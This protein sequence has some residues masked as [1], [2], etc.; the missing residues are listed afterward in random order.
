MHGG[1]R[2]LEIARTRAHWVGGG[3]WAVALN[4]TA[5]TDEIKVTLLA[6]AVVDD[7]I[8]VSGIVQVI[9]RPD[10][11][12]S[13]IP[14]LTLAAL[15]GPPLGLIGAHLLPNGRTV[16]ASWTYARPADV[17]AEYEGRID[18]IDLAYR[19]GGVVLEAASGP[20]MFRF[21]VPNGGALGVG[22]Q[23]RTSVRE[24]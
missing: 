13:N 10:V 17:F 2:D 24:T 23:R 11:R 6:L 20:W 22:S 18:T 7:V 21:S 8:R 14:T 12:L 19:A 5:A 1:A 9:R 3:P 4:E 15:D 16:W